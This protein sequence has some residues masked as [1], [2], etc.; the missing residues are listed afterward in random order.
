MA[1]RDDDKLMAGMLRRNLAHSSVRETAAPG[2]D[3][4]PPDI[5]AAYYEHSLG[6]D[7]STRYEL[8]FSNCASCREQLAAMVRAEE[9]PQPKTGWPWLW[10]PYLLPPAGS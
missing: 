8:H 9:A 5:L 4:P 7:E 2:N 1:S 3:C 6:E 10:S